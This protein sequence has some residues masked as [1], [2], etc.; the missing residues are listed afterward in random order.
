M[1]RKTLKKILR[2]AMIILPH[3]CVLI[4]GRTS[5][6]LAEI[7]CGAPN[8]CIVT[9]DNYYK[10]T[11]SGGGQE[12][13]TIEHIDHSCVGICYIT[14]WS[15][16]KW[17][18]IPPGTVVYVHSVNKFYW[19]G[20]GWHG[21]GKPQNCGVGPYIN[22]SVDIGADYS[23]EWSQGEI[24]PKTIQEVYPNGCSDIPTQIY[25]NFNLGAAPDNCVK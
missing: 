18:I 15:W 24:W 13:Q 23:H 12:G 7:A 10:Y 1:G 8:S 5:A 6:C 16:S 19:D 14:D 11:S 21:L 9:I 17:R 3:I 22:F 2:Q 25:T 4:L 20:I